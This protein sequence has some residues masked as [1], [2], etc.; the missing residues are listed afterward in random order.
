MKQKDNDNQSFVTDSFSHILLRFN[1]INLERKFFENDDKYF[2]HMLWAKCMPKELLDFISQD[3]YFKLLYNL[4]F[5]YGTA[6]DILLNSSRW[7]I[8]TI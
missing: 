7:R 4:T 8:L 3:Y 5:K 6:N 1:P 2:I